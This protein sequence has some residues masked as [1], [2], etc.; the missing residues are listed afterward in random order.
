MHEATLKGATDMLRKMNEKMGYPDWILEDTFLL[1]KYGFASAFKSGMIVSEFKL[2]AAAHQFKLAADSIGTPIDF[3]HNWLRPQDFFQMEY[4][5]FVNDLVGLSSFLAKPIYDYSAPQVYNFG[6]FGT[7]IGGEIAK[8]VNYK[9]N[10]QRGS[11]GDLLDWWDP[12]DKTFYDGIKTCLKEQRMAEGGGVFGDAPTGEYDSA[13]GRIQETSDDCLT[14]ALSAMG[15]INIA[16][17]AWRRWASAFNEDI[18]EKRFPG[19]DYSSEQLFFIRFGNMW[20]DYQAMSDLRK[21]QCSSRQRVFSGIQNSRT[22]AAAFGCKAGAPMNP[23]KKCELWGN[24]TRFV[25]TQDDSGKSG[26]EAGGSSGSGKSEDKNSD[27][28]GGGGGI[29]VGCVCFLLGAVLGAGVYRL[30]AAPPSAQGRP[31]VETELRD[32]A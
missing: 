30:S 24:E 29:L 26:G 19:L 31:E 7:L 3:D 32:R 20:C 21:G 6:G 14:E 9:Q 1:R 8:A 11:D 28:G 13:A 23:S 17:L 16:H 25:S 22:F 10:V 27:S 2:T 18:N 15:G 4:H 12:E 5:E